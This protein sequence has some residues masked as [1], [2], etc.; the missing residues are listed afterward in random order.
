MMSLY[1]SASHYVQN[2]KHLQKLGCRKDKF[3][4]HKSKE[5]IL[6]HN[7]LLAWVISRSQEKDCSVIYF[8]FDNITFLGYQLAQRVIC[9]AA[10]GKLGKWY[11][12]VLCGIT[13]LERRRYRLEWFCK[14]LFMKFNISCLN[15]NMV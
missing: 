10:R 12:A 9:I 11:H 14:M 4:D 13:V 2:W 15:R 1:F 3:W 8:V 7:F 5:K 6:A